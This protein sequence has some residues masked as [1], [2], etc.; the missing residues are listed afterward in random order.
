MSEKTKAGKADPQVKHTGKVG[1]TENERFQALENLQEIQQMPSINAVNLNYF[2]QEQCEPG[3]SFGPFRRT[4]YLLHF[5]R[6]GKGRLIKEEKTY[7]I[8]SGQV[9]LIFP[10]EETIYQA[11]E[12][13][14]WL[15][16]WVG[17]QGI[18]VEDMMRKAGFT[19]ASPVVTCRNMDAMMVTMDAILAAK[20]LVYTN[21]L[22]RLGYL[23]QLIALLTQNNDQ[24]E[25]EPAAAED[26]DSLYVRA[27]VNMLINPANPQIRVSDVANAIGISR[28]YL[29][30][31][32]KNAMKVSPQGFQLNFRME[33]AGNLL[34]STR[35]S[36][37]AVAEE[38]G[39]TD[40]L[41]FSKSFR[42]HFGMS[43][44]DFREQKVVLL[45]GNKKGSYTSGHPL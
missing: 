7:F 20:D 34:R 39:Y 22:L 4:S 27:A 18:L 37:S 43:P 42:R 15:Y 16:T 5:I 10:G 14:P 33:K 32:F 40:V 13:D 44:T 38:L 26:M 24:P 12:E 23:Y 1:L 41:S 36:V 29:S 9:F 8:H 17:F 28:G 11:D 31:I 6:S 25:T 30:I 2:G 21:E 3:Y 19:P 35:L 45:T